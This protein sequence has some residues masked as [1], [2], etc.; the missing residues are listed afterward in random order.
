MASFKQT[1]EE[2][3]GTA[4]KWTQNRFLGNNTFG[5]DGVCAPLA[6]KWILNRKIGINFK[7]DTALDEGRNEVMQLKINQHTP[8]MVDY[9]GEYLS[10][11]GI[12]ETEY[13]EAQ[14]ES[15]IDALLNKVFGRGYYFIG[16]SS[17][18]APNTRPIGHALAID[19]VSYKFFDPDYGQASF[20][21]FQ[22][23][24]S[25]VRVWLRSAYPTMTQ[26]GFIKRY[27]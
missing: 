9:V 6:A 1:V 19:A 2:N 25:F 22:A 26:A 5:R 14:A 20:N 21:T 24:I 23:L 3:G 8:A 12:R 17:R 27:E 7:A 11:A 15:V 10:F 16:I 4:K 18:M 13:F